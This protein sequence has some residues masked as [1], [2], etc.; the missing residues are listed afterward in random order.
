[1]AGLST[2][3]AAQIEALQLSERLISTVVRA[4]YDDEKVVVIDNLLRI[5][6]LRDKEDDLGAQLGLQPKQVR[7]ALAELE[8]EGLVQQESMP[9]ETQGGRK[10]SYWYVDL[11]RAVSV[12]RL[13][14]YLMQNKLKEAEKRELARQT[15]LCP[16]CQ[17]TF[18][19][20]EIQKLV[21]GARGFCCSHCCPSDSHESC[22]KAPYSLVD[23]DN[24]ERL[25]AVT[26]DL[27]QLKEQLSE[28]TSP[29]CA[30]TGIF[31]LVKELHD[32][33]VPSNL[34]SELRA[35]GVGGGG[36]AA[37]GASRLA[38]F[39][40]DTFSLHAGYAAQS[41]AASSTNLSSKRA[42]ELLYTKNALGQEVV[43]EI[44]VGSSDE[45]EDEDVK[46]AMASAALATRGAAAASGAK[47]P[48]KAQ[49]IFLKGS[50]IQNT[51]ASESMDVADEQEQ[52]ETDEQQLSLAPIDDAAGSHKERLRAELERR[53]QNG[54]ENGQ[55]A[56]GE[57][58]D[59]VEWEDPSC[60]EEAGTNNSSNRRS[61][62]TF[63]IQDRTIDLED[64]TEDDI[65]LMT[66]DQ[67]IHYYKCTTSTAFS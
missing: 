26:S 40:D 59:D 45:E 18:G 12:I 58:I 60:L 50:R 51:A 13:R 23:F 55:S 30:R 20:L 35:R 49:P 10:A 36:N 34:P 8:R 5:K 21:N 46:A 66:N 57:E 28:S 61:G 32:R 42:M 39:K 52:Q 3:D 24:R 2:S 25:D 37:H 15:Y 6:Y 43:V 19:V 22:T 31:E 16:Q 14:V 67:Y 7:S 9:D 44:E 1:M 17:A 65:D 41:R 53:R 54:Q 33:V 27:A 4:L 11:R 38:R 63:T 62:V 56:E 48:R 64:I 29:G 47:R